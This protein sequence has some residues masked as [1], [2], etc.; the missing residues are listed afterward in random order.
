MANKYNIVVGVKIDQNSN[1][2]QQIQNALNKSTFKINLDLAH[3]RTQLQSV[4][5][6]LKVNVGGAVGGGGTA[7]ATGAGSETSGLMNPAS[8]ITR[9]ESVKTYLDEQNQEIRELRTGYD[10]LGRSIS[11]VNRL[12]QTEDG[13]VRER[14]SST[15]EEGN[16][17]NKNA[18]AYENLSARLEHL[19]TNGQIN[20]KQYAEFKQRLEQLNPSLDKT[21]GKVDQFEKSKAFKQLGQDISDAGKHA[22]SFGDMLKTAYEKFAKLTPRIATS[23]RNVC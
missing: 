5:D 7:G 4:F 19:R 17:I 16:L 10:D 20:N 2:S 1:I 23:Y 9:N 22:M 3:L 13:I 15:Q 18:Q 8:Q 12:R 11:E 14:I 6:G 21:K